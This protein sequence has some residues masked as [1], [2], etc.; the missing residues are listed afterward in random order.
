MITSIGI[1]NFRSIHDAKLDT[2]GITVLTGAN[3]SG[4]SSII[5]S[6]L[7]LKNAVTNS[8]QS[9][10]TITNLGFINLGGIKE[11]VYR[12]DEDD[13]IE[14]SI[15]TNAG[16]APTMYEVDLG[17]M[18]SSCF[19]VEI[20]TLKVKAA[21]GIG[22]PYTGSESVKIESEM[23]PNEYSITWNGFTA[24]A[25]RNQDTANSSVNI[26]RQVSKPQIVYDIERAMNAPIKSIASIDFTPIRRGF[27]KPF[28]APVPLT[29]QITTED[30]IATLLYADR[31]LAGDVAHYLE[32]IVDRRF[33][34][35][36]VPNTTNFYLQTRDEKTGMTADLVNEGLGTNQLVTILAKALYK[37]SEFICIDEPEIHLHPT[38]IDKLVNVLI[39]I[40]K[41]RKKQF[42]ISTHSEHFINALLN[43]VVKKRVT[44]EEVKVYH[45]TKEGWDTQIEEQKI[46]AEGQIEGGLA[47]FYAAELA[48]W[49]TFFKVDE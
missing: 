27:T 8:N 3:N 23:L 31:E 41:Q 5:Y 21:L 15:T 30:E 12:K 47:H 34:V 46:N 48:S 29:Q 19:Y 45:L 2:G 33:S 25:T 37:N 14:L 38:L 24:K 26:P 43:A 36:P 40:V 28:F 4:K 20:P 9:L 39:D 22:F 49:S 10:D 18:F 32:K 7:T 44:P 17:G 13:A 16:I 11:T 6:L 1:K 42:L 35:N